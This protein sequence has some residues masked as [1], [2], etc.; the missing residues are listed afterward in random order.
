MPDSNSRAAN[1]RQHSR[2]K[3]IRI[4]DDN[5]S[6]VWMTRMARSLS[7]LISSQVVV[8]KKPGYFCFSMPGGFHEWEIKK[9]RKHLEELGIKVEVCIVDS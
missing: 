4:L 8:S 2:H 3:V 5:V 6:G 1:A 7:L 9:I